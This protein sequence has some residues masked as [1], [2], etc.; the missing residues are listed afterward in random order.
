MEKHDGVVSVVNSDEKFE[1]HLDNP[2]FTAKEV[3]VSRLYL[4]C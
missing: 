1:V 3:E 2:Y 4:R